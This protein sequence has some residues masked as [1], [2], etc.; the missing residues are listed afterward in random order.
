MRVTPLSRKDTPIAYTAERNDIPGCA[1]PTCSV[2]K[3]CDDKSVKEAFFVSCKVSDFTPP[4]KTFFA[5]SHPRPVLAENKIL[6]E[7]TRTINFNTVEPGNQ[8]IGCSNRS[9]NVFTESSNRPRVQILINFLESEKT[10]Y[11]SLTV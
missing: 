6:V 7:D 11:I 2:R 8:D 3:K 10:N 9:D 4:S 5:I 1:G